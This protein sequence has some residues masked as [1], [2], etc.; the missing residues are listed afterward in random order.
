MRPLRLLLDGFGSYRE[1][2]EVDF[3]GVDFFALVGPTG[4][5]KS[6][7]IDGLCFALYG[8]VPRWGKENV[9]AQALAPAANAC[10]VALVFEAAGKRYGA[11]RA[12]ARNARGQVN[13]KEARLELL[14]PSVP[15][16]ASLAELLEASVQPLAEGPEQ[17]KSAATEI[18]GLTYEHFTQSVLLPQGRFSEFLHA[19]ASERQNLLVELLAF[20]VYEVV[21]QKARERAKLA[22]EL[23]QR[24]QDVLAELSDATE[25]A[26]MA[27]CDRV[28]GLADLAAVVEERLGVLAGLATAAAEAAA[29]AE[30]VRAEAGLLA[31]VRTPGEVPGLAQRIGAADRDVTRCRAD[32]D[33]ADQAEQE[34]GQARDALPDKSRLERLRD[35]YGQQRE[36]A[37]ARAKQEKALADRQAEQDAREGILQ[38]AEAELD[39][40]RAACS[41]AERTHAAIAVAQDLA[42]GA[43][44]PVCLQPVT[45]LPHHPVPADLA[46]AREAVDAAGAAAIKARAGREQ[47]AKA[48][49]VAA[50]DLETTS[51]QAE[52]IAVLIADAS[53]EP[54]IRALIEAIAVADERFGKARVAARDARAAAAVAE[55]RR[56]GLDD[57]ERRAWAAL[58][59]VRD[60]VVQLGAP[61]VDGSDLAAAW[62]ALAGWAAGQSA[63]RARR[64]ADVDEAAGAARV[65]VASAE[66]ALRE[67]L[68]ASGIDVV[69][70]ARALAAVATHR[71]RAAHRLQAVRADRKKA[72]ELEVQVRRHVEDEQVASMLGRLLRAS[73]F[74]RW[75]CGEALDS[76][77]AEAS[78]TLMELSGGQYQLDRAVGGRLPGR[79]RAAAGA[80]VVGRGDVPGLAGTGSGP[81]PAGDR[82]VGRDAGPELDVP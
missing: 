54:E 76:L 59:S 47:A 69:E 68:A 35:A 3:S 77:V 73:S 64:L 12:L 24:A 13:T 6:T 31:A 7:V 37:A 50:R 30:A 62:E 44:C 78:E 41:A 18:L 71:E 28:T 58:H 53:S 16:G 42:V 15:A 45:T 1:P 40:A 75:L 66:R 17:V 79:G 55:R 21:G 57:E 9:I 5:G 46:G 39:H 70:V 14:D 4:S 19:K 51:Q 33:R 29:A 80:H 63:E 49:A 74:E 48:A 65:K 72:A 8:T 23:A 2:A 67:M 61:V 56:A 26:E 34:A 38:A 52:R 36:V 43:D 81:V 10:R 32:R 82:A 60:S 20:G 27:A 11:V 22:G 25:E